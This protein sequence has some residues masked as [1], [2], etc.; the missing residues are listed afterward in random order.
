VKNQTDVI[1]SRPAFPVWVVVVAAF[2]TVVVVILSVFTN[3]L[4]NT[5]REAAAAGTP[6]PPVELDLSWAPPVIA[7]IIIG[8][9]I[10]IIVGGLL[11]KK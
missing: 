5:Y 8:T 9:A 2:S 4:Q 7:A 6:I 11:K 3:I 1:S 10:G